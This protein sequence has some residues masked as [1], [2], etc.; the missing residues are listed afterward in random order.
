MF[1]LNVFWQKR[2]IDGFHMPIFPKYEEALLNQSANSNLMSGVVKMLLVGA[3]YTYS[4]TH[5]FLSDVPSGAR[6]GI[7]AALANKTNI[8]GAF[9]SDGT[10][11]SSLVAVQATAIIMFIDTGSESTSR[12]VSYTNVATGLPLTP[13]TTDT[14]TLA[15]PST[16]FNR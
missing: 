4:G 14:I 8:N 13:N 1:S 10:V 11:F 6:V 5:Q 16:L 15:S 9:D 2:Q 7:S 3:A 12:L